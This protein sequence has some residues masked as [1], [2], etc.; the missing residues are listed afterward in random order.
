MSPLLVQFHVAGNPSM[1]GM[2]RPEKKNDQLKHCL[3]WVAWPLEGGK[4][5]VKW[6]DSCTYTHCKTPQE[7]GYLNDN[8][9]GHSEPNKFSLS[10]PE[11]GDLFYVHP[12]SQ[13]KF[14]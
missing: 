9:L 2:F 7:G 6:S 12:F 3:D 4:I 1:V 10:S 11:E 14:D 13:S 5:C 8:N